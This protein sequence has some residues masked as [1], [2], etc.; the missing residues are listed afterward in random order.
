M[1]GPL[2]LVPFRESPVRGPFG[3]SCGGCLVWVTLRG[4][5]CGSSVFVTCR[6]T[7]CYR[8]LAGALML[9]V[10]CGD[11]LSGVTCGQPVWVTCWGSI[12]RS[13]VVGPFYWVSC[14]CS[15]VGCP[16]CR[17]CVG[18]RLG[19]HLRGITCAVSAVVVTCGSHV[20][21]HLCGS[22]MW[23]S[24]GESHFGVPCQWTLW[25]SPAMG[26][27][28]GSPVG[29]PLEPGPFSVTPG[30]SPGNTLEGIHFWGSPG[31]TSVERGP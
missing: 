15:P 24:C 23:F 26:S 29:G 14:M 7:P 8:S 11:H 21:C 5:L 18:S 27:L 12:W 22:P 25:R 4:F 16:L 17:A 19:L 6:G 30:V 3:V 9:G 31:G 10:S 28:Q 13:H 2:W 1:W 20:T